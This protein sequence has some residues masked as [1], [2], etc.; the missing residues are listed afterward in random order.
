MYKLIGISSVKRLSDNAC[1]PSSDDNSDYKAYKLWLEEGNI[2]EPEFTDEEI[3]QQEI[4]KQLQEAKAYLAST[5]F[6]Y[7]R[8]LETGEVVPEAVVL[9]RT[10]SREFIRANTI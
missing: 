7:A 10:E 9:K 1:I 6:Y 2:P 4:Q 5:D 3:A 8:F